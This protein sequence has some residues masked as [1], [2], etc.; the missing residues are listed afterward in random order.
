M[1]VTVIE[2]DLML[3]SIII[4]HLKDEKIETNL[5]TRGDHALDTLKRVVPD[6][7]ILDIFLPGQ[8]GLDLL[9]AMREDPDLKKV[10]V[11]VVS[12]TDQKKDRERA[13]GLGA[14]FM[15]KAGVTPHDIV[16][17]VKKMLVAS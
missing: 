9:S 1:K 6:V 17:Q 15:L 4:R 8:N 10:R 7:V 14:S 16:E 2:D 3:A 13:V 5:I 12:N 11:L